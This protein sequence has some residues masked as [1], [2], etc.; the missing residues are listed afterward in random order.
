MNNS[1][2]CG[3][4]WIFPCSLFIVL[5][6]GCAG[7]AHIN[8]ISVSN[9]IVSANIKGMPLIEVLASLDAALQQDNSRY[10]IELF[11]TN[12]WNGTRL[13]LNYPFTDQ[14]ETSVVSNMPLISFSNDS[15]TLESFL[16][17]LKEQSKW[18]MSLNYTN[19]MFF[20]SGRPPDD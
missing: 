16:E 9:E 2:F 7:P 6:I 19:D 3:H 17:E 15:C 8:N 10:S 13:E 4:A 14:Q 5:W 18:S 11:H 12:Y 20:I 1:I